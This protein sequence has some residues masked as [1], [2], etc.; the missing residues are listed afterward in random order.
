MIPVEVETYLAN[1]PGEV[2]R[3]SRASAE[4]VLQTLGVALNTEFADFYL[5][6]QGCFI[7]PRPVSELMDIDGP[8]I[9]N[10]AAELGYVQD[11]YDLPANYL[12]LTT[13]EG[14]GMYLYAINSGT[15]YDMDF[16]NLP[17]LLTNKL[18]PRWPDFNAFLIWFFSE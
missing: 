2:L 14:E 8:E 11:R 15:V 3:A 1:A 16:D 17:D 9:P 5:K 13:D 10:I 12:P 18:P 6:Y 7:S 4:K